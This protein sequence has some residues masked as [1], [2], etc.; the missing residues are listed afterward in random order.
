MK[1]FKPYVNEKSEILPRL[2]NKSFYSMALTLTTVTSV[3]DA[4]VLMY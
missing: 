2:F 3:H 1:S 4:I